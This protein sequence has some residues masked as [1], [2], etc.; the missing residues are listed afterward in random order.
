MPADATPL[1]LWL[2]RGF[3]AVVFLTRRRRLV[4][5]ILLGRSWRRG[6]GRDTDTA[7]DGLAYRAF[8]WTYA[9]RLLAQFGD[10]LV[11]HIGLRRWPALLCKIARDRGLRRI[12]HL[13]TR[14]SRET[15]YTCKLLLRRE[16]AVARRRVGLCS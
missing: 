9:R 6:S 7:A 11:G 14:C 2:R 3:L 1:L 15:A 10:E 16:D 13:A 4:V 5:V 8:H 12:I